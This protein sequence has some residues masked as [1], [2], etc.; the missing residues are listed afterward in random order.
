MKNN[1]TTRR[2]FLGQVAGAISFPLFVQ[3]KVFGANDRINMG[4]IGT[5]NQGRR[6]LRGFMNFP[7][8]RA[9]AV[10]DVRSEYLNS[11]RDRVNKKYGN[12]DCRTYKDWREVIAR[13]DIDAIHIA[14]PDHWHAVISIAAMKAGKDV[15][16]Q[17]PETLT[18]REGREMVK[19]ARRYNRVFSG[20]SQRVWGYYNWFHKMV[21]GGR[22][23]QLEEAWVTVGG[24]SGPCNLKPEPVP[25]SVDW[26][27][28]LG[29]APWRPYA[30]KLVNR[31]FRPYMDYSGGATT[32]FGCHVFGTALFCCKLHKT[33]PVEVLNPV[34]TGEQGNTY[35]FENGI[36]IH[37]R[38]YDKQGRARGGRG[39]LLTFKGSEGEIS[40][41]GDKDGKK[42][43]PPKIYIPNY[44]GHGGFFGDFVHCLRT[45]EKPFRDIEIA[46]RTAT[47]CH[48]GNI[49]YWLN[50]SLK[51]DPV[52]EEI[53]G[54]PEASRWLDR[55]KREPWTL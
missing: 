4:F 51:W 16:C 40:E 45:R 39:N 36:K 22:I 44:K 50:R 9:V 5:G 26:D 12:K 47:V 8:V 46:H 43:K 19:V 24:P 3:S 23:G 6:D 48:L 55:S 13:D 34:D 49:S 27:M 2:R 15:F 54:D 20:G 42:E 38:G 37:H 52:K 25:A 11:A 29:P 35:V 28:W 17:K 41:R 14:T 30:E 1:A 10:C 18:I 7:E 32:D 53:I 31:G 21:Y 33:G